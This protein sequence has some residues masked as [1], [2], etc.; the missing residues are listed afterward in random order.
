MC[1]LLAVYFVAIIVFLSAHGTDPIISSSS[2]AIIVRPRIY[3]KIIRRRRDISDNDGLE[4]LKMIEVG[5]W[6][7]QLSPENNFVVAPSL[8][9]EWVS[10]N[11]DVRARSV[12]ECDYKLGVVRG[13][14]TTSRV[15]VTLCGR[16]VTG[17]INVSGVIFF[18]QPTNSTNG[19]HH[20][21]M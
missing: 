2:A 1:S 11:G 14:E 7:L 18:L 10:G 13:L 4:K 16:C 6:T 8:Q 21:Y 19:E 20:L 5:D 9:A 15:A 17:Y 3:E 12:S